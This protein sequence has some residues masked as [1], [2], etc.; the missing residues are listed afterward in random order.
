MGA[1]MGLTSFN[2][3]VEDRTLFSSRSKLPTERI[4]MRLPH[5]LVVAMAITACTPI[6]GEAENKVASAAQPV[7]IP[8]VDPQGCPDLI[9]PQFWLSAAMFLDT[10]SFKPSS[11]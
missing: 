7:Q 2:M 6:P 4:Y 8:C 1:D 9:P 10:R 11:C 5:A 3:C